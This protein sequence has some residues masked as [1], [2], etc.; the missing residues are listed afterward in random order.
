MDQQKFEALFDQTIDN[1]RHL[2]VVKGGEYAGSSD[3]LANF[4]RGA[5]LTGVTPMQCLFVYMSKHYDAVATFIRDDATGKSRPR[6]EP[7]TGRVDDLINYC[8]LLKALMEEAGAGDDVIH[9]GDFLNPP[10]KAPA[11]DRMVLQLFSANKAEFSA[12]FLPT[13]REAHDFLVAAQQHSGP[14]YLRFQG[15]LVT[16]WRW[17]SESE[18]RSL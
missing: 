4:K 1:I 10:D 12:L 15:H 16:A 3:R 8:I 7:I 6:S 13:A 11:G 17:E 18:W 14:G 5:E 9:L 2:L